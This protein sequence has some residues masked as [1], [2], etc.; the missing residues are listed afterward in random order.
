MPEIR[1]MTLKDAKRKLKDLNLEIQ[2]SVELEQNSKE[3]EIIIKEQTPK[4]GIKVNKGSKISVE[5]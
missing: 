1:E 2:L 5:I 4:P 3:E